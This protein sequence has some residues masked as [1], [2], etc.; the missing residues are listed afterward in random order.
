[1]KRLCFGTLL[2]LIYQARSQGVHYKDICEEVFEAFGATP[3]LQRDGSLPTHLKT[4]YKNVP[5]DVI[6]ATRNSRYEDV[7]YKFEDSVSKLV[8]EKKKQLFIFAV[9]AV[10]QDDPIDM[11]IPI[12]YN[13]DFTKRA[14]LQNDK[15]QFSPLL[16]AIFRYAIVNV[17]NAECKDSLRKFESD[18]LSR[19]EVKGQIFIDPLELQLAEN[20]DDVVHLM[21]TLHDPNFDRTFTKV[22]TVRVTEMV[23]PSTADIYCADL[24]NGKLNFAKVKSY[25]ADNIGAYVNSRSAIKRYADLGKSPMALGIR[26]LLTFQKAYGNNAESMLGELLLYIFLEQELHAPKLL[27]K[28]EFSENGLLLASKSDGVHLLATTER[29]RPFNQLV[30]GASNIEGDLCTAANRAIEKILAIKE[31]QDVEFAQVENT[32]QRM[33]FDEATSEYIRNIMIP[34]RQ[35]IA[36]PDMA[37]GMFLG[38]SLNVDPE[39]KDPAM[40][41][42]AAQ[43]QMSKD[44][45]NLKSYLKKQIQDK[46]LEGY[47]FYCYVLPFNDAPAE[48]TGL[49]DEI[50]E[51][52]GNL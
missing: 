10:L 24:R 22:D 28:I 25:L 30:F 38:Y 43:E 35:Y 15:F 17:S 51:G 14:I 7:I 8:D 39:I 32:T 19:V 6:T 34:S 2:Q 47:A 45:G 42:V 50:L 40:Y 9:R 46:G 13:S 44:I 18:F 27:T 41:R 49:I 31:N 16:V 20:E 29:G 12:G 23:H 26:A 33:I 36:P 4:G 52:G 5:E 37:F 11:D 1:M 48:R 21:G 3:G